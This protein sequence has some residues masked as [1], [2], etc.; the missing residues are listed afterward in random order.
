MYSTAKGQSTVEVKGNDLSQKNIDTLFAKE[1]RLK[2]MNEWDANTFEDHLGKK[3]AWGIFTGRSFSG[4]KT[5][6][7]SLASFVRGKI[8]NM[9]EI[10]AELKKKMGTEEE[11]FEGEVPLAKV[12]D[13][14]RDIVAADKAANH[15]FVYLFESWLHKTTGEFLHYLNSQFGLPSFSIHC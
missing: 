8:I 2:T 1:F 13:A 5:V 12:E 3:V 6:A 15:K 9:A 14:I 4:K 7:A 10:A 11:P